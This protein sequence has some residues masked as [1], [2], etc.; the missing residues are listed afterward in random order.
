[1]D[2][3][4]ITDVLVRCIIG[5]NPSERLM[6]QPLAIGMA[7]DL[8]TRQ[9]ARS[10]ALTDT[11]DY[12]SLGALASYV[13]NAG[14]FGLL[15]T[16]LEAVAAAVLAAVPSALRP[17]AVTVS[18]RKFLALGG[19]GDVTLTV[20]RVPEDFTLDQAE[21]YRHG[22]FRLELVTG[23]SE[24]EVA[25]LFPITTGLWLRARLGPY[26]HN[27]HNPTGIS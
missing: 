2:R 3:I 10:G 14:A 23:L 4:A 17:K 9:A 26:E 21:I 20:V 13:L 16:G 19:N 15:E 27:S 1:M 6:R 24:G 5:V 25:G 7:L 8:D 12:S 11:I 22:D 18:A